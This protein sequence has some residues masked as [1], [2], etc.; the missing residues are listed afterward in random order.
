MI[1]NFIKLT[2]RNLW[3]NRSYSFL[4]IFGLAIGIACA[5]LIF[6]WVEDELSYDQFPRK[7]L[8]YYIRENQTNDGKVRTFG[9][10]PVP[11]APAIMKEIPGV[12]EACRVKGRKFLFSLND[13]GIYEQGAYTDPSFVR[14][15]GL[16][17][18]EGNNRD[19]FAQ[20]T[21][22]VISRKMARQFFGDEPAVGKTL[23]MNNLKEYK[24]SAVVGDFPVN[25]TVQLD[26]MIPFQTFYNEN[27]DA[28]RMDNWYINQ[29]VTYVEL[30]PGA[31]A[32]TVGKQLHGFIQ[33]KQPDANA[34]CFLHS[35]N[36]WHLRDQF[37][38][39]KLVGGR[40]GFVKLFVGIAWIIL[41][42]ACVNFMNLAT[43]RSDKR[44]K[45][46]G[47][48]KVL[49]AERRGLIAQFIGE[50]MILSGIAVAVGVLLITLVMPAFSLL[51]GKPLDVH[52]TS[53]L[54]L[55]A[56]AVI[57]L[58]CGLVAGSYPA[59]YLS[60]FNP[61]YVFKGMRMKGVGAAL[62]RKG[63]VVMQFTVSVVLIIST[64]IIY[65]QI[66]HIRHRDIGYNKYNLVTVNVRGDMVKH[67]NEIRQDLLR[68]GSI[69]NAGLN[70][71]STLWLGDNGAGAKWDGQLPGQDP[72]ISFRSI[73]PGFLATA[74]M[75][76]A[77][78]RDFRADLP[79][80]DSMHVLVTESLAQMMGKGS[81]IG[82]RIWFGTNPPLTVVGVVKDIVF[83]DM[84]GKPEPA[85]FSYGTDNAMF[86]FARIKTGA[87][88]ATALAQM[89][90]VLKKDNPGYPFEYSFVNED[91]DA[92]FRSE[93]LIG[94]LSRLFATLAIVISCLGLFGLSAYMAERRVKE[95]GIRKVLGAS[96]TGL[97]GLLSKEFLQLVGL[98]TLIAFPV[99]WY[100]MD[101]W[102]RGYAYR[103]GVEWWVFA[104][105]G[106]AALLIALA[107]VSFQSLRA[108]LM[109]PARSLRSE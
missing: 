50:A 35:A 54:H 81:A 56:L 42:I 75:Q 99:A 27:N 60:S 97:T 51:I 72:L 100:A 101:H 28:G 6:L 36:D 46:V 77:E 30:K 63:L 48:R 41:F 105:A 44:S 69:G 86:L 53:P 61:I 106:M 83:G 98:S 74:G 20:L 11:L 16:P 21:N 68:T 3:K 71:F 5:G 31:S 67:F 93:Q 78:G 1:P 79:D 39:G 49:G 12:A 13:K 55:G 25:S 24:V 29:L 85:M 23:R 107:T 2:F 87:N 34:K 91:F 104:A 4:N 102:L 108:A 96:I 95:I 76:L 47:V 18:V 109:N 17:F 84:Y 65:R 45:E 59:L 38:D 9:S 90:A 89:E 73:T 88:P 22:I 43:A 33:T 66:E 15:F 40:I 80:A 58:I 94:L 103:I 57:T 37:E 52:L 26:W 8:V 19:A 62:V 82:K 70:S 32:A 7:D 92:I 64:V 10:T 14:M